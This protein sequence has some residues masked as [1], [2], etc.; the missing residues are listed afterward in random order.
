MISLLNCGKAL[1]W[2]HFVKNSSSRP[3][4]S[5]LIIIVYRTL[6]SLNIV[7]TTPLM[8]PPQR[9]GK[10]PPRCRL[11]GWK[12]TR[13]LLI[14]LWEGTVTALLST[15]PSR[16]WLQWVDGT[17]HYIWQEWQS[18]IPTWP[19]LAQVGQGHSFSPWCFAGVL[20]LL[21]KRFC[22]TGM[23]PSWSFGW[24][25]QPYIGTFTG[26]PAPSLGYMRQKKTQGTKYYVIS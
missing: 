7:S 24:R 21:S 4:F 16:T 23:A 9:G 20:W 15:Q 3:P 11:V 22:L 19:L 13:S 18:G 8:K 25:E 17:S 1:L 14:L 5:Q 12:S 2:K 26:M 6:V 10:G